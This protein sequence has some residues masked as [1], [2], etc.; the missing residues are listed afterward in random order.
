MRPVEWTISELA[1][2]IKKRIANKFDS[3]IAI[4]GGTGNGKSTFLYKLF[5]KFNDFKIEDKLT[6][7]RTEMIHLIKD[8]KNSYCWNDELISSAN[9][10]KFYDQ[11]QIELI[12]I[13]TKYRSNLNIVA[14]AVPVFFT[15]DKELL[16]LF[17]MHINIIERG[18]ACIHFPRLGRM[19][20]D[21]PWDCK[22]NSR[23]EE[24]WSEKLQKNPKFKIPYTKYTTCVGYCYF[25]KMTDKQE[26]Y[27]EYLRD[28]KKA[29]AENK[30]DDENGNGSENNFYKNVLSMI[31]SNKINEQELLNI[32]LIND[33][34]LSSVKAR[35]GQMLRDEGNERTLGDFLKESSKVINSN[36]L[37]NNTQDIVITNI[38]L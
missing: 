34:K 8:F 33:K 22:I 10:R 26:K 1:E 2:I 28:K 18:I 11:E 30:T 25:G 7:S 38:D 23:L 24:R 37:H 36:S 27:Y 17:G 35:L 13:L 31:K 12:E 3:N 16:K 4:T 21:D 32:C 29:E 20:T 9:K 19:Y 14:G 5:N 15:L 6:Y